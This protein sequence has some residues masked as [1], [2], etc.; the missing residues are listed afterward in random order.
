MLQIILIGN[1]M[2]QTSPEFAFT[3]Y[4]QDAIGNIDSVVIGYDH[5]EICGNLNNMFGE[6]AITTPYDSVFEMRLKG[7][8]T[9]Q[10]MPDSKKAIS[11]YEG[12]CMPYGAAADVEVIV[13]AKYKPIRFSWDRN[14]F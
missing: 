8:V 1:A 4:A 11:C 6:F 9:L 14:V 2:A 3:L 13:R 7:D 10:S 12:D 5:N